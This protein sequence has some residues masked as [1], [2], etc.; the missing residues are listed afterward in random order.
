MWP[1]NGSSAGRWATAGFR[2]IQALC[3]PWEPKVD[4]L[5]WETGWSTWFLPPKALGSLAAIWERP[6]HDYFRVAE[7][8]ASHLDT[9]V[10][11]MSSPQ[12]DDFPVTACP[13]TQAMLGPHSTGAGGTLAGGRGTR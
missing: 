6:R 4:V 13:S 3:T 7:N 2:E 8:D 1:A 9:D 5:R 12:R 10:Q 11:T